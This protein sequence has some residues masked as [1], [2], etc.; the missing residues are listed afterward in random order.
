MIGGAVLIIGLLATLLLNRQQPVTVLPSASQSPV[1]QQNIPYPDVPR[2]SPTDA[3]TQL[4]S[5]QAIVVDVR[6]VENYQAAHVEGAISIPL[7]ALEARMQ[8]LPK[9]GEIITY[10]T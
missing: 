8:E 5:G 3:K 7:D 4:D 1:A 2:M 10:C 9:N 6:A